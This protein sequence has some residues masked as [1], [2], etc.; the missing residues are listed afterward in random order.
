MKHSESNTESWAKRVR[1]SHL[2]M[3]AWTFAW[4]GTMVLAD[5][6]ELYEWYTSGLMSMAA[7]I[8]NALI[9]LGLIV[10]FMRYLQDLDELHRKIQLGALALAMGVGL[11]GSFSY[12]LLITAQFVTDPEVNDLILLMVLTYVAG[13]L[14]GQVKYR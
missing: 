1:K 11:V 6:A 8:F 4:S 5:K 14:F 12:S 9:G 2:R 7:I 13:I 3:L 10:N